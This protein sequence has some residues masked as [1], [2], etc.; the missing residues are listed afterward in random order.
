MKRVLLLCMA[1][2]LIGSLVLS[3]CGEQPGAGGTFVMGLDDQFPPMGYRDNSGKIVGFDVDIATEVCKRLNMELKLE[4]I[5]WTIKENE[6]DANMVDCLWNGYT[7]TDERKAKVLF[8]EPYMKNRQILIIKSD[9]SYAE[10][11]DFEGK[12]VALQSGSSAADAL[13]SNAEFKESLG[14][15]IFFDDNN[16][17]LMD[18]EAGGCDAVL[19]DEI[20]ARYYAKDGKYKV[21]DISLADEEF[22]IGFRKEDTELMQ[23]VQKTLK[24]M[25]TDGKLAEISTKWFGKDITTI[26]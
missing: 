3:G 8:T 25:A 23:K 18:L 6:L 22:G 16:K 14:Q 20:V 15:V 5:D 12:K 24:E 1:L 26:Q 11:K 21:L 2:L 4:P 7:I 19:M 13:D 9:A 10:L 17:A